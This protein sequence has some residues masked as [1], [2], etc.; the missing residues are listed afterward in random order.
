VDTAVEPLIA[1]LL[2]AFGVGLL[3]RR[4]RL[5]YTLAL[6]V[7]GLALG[8][9]DVE[10]FK[11]IRL[12][13]DLLF[14]LLLPP[15]LFEASFHLDWTRFRRDAP[16]TFLLAVPGPIIATTIT[17][18]LTMVLLRAFGWESFGWTEAFLLGAIV[19]PTDPV[20]VLSL[21]RALDV[22]RR[23]H[24]LVEGESLLND[25]IAVVL[26]L[27]V[28]ATAGLAVRSDAPS[29]LSMHDAVLYGLRTFFWMAGGGIAIGSLVGLAAS[30]VTRA[31][32]DHLVEVAL[33]AIVAW[34]SFLVAESVQASGVLACVAAGVVHG[35]VGA[36][37]SMSPTTRM[38]VID[39]WEFMAFFANTLVFLLVGLELDLGTLSTVVVPIVLALGAVLVARIAVVTLAWGAARASRRLDDIPLRWVPVL[40]WGGIRGS[41]SMVLV[42]GLP[43]GL[44]SRNF[45]VVLV[46]GVAA[47]SLL[48]QGLTMRP[49]VTRLGLSG[50]AT[51]NSIERAW[52]ERM[53]ASRALAE[54]D[55][56]VDDGR[57][58]PNDAERIREPYT[59][60]RA[61]ATRT[62]D[63]AGEGAKGRLLEQARRHLV[64]IERDVLDEAVI[65]GVASDP[66][67]RAL[68]DEIARKREA[69]S[70]DS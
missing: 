37:R 19:S 43:Y 52:T 33:T 22:D 41:V 11:A 63:S 46:F 35:N 25:G 3:A 59:R 12:T 23:L 39:F 31:I 58:A 40:V 29:I 5:P 55:R 61:D 48:L 10:A 42:L 26:F 1:L 24:L 66:V 18:T 14:V 30:A 69:I 50:T 54:I 45:L 49:L 9:L 32:D 7:A 56:W 38:A 4:F 44:E 67:A 13:P 62:L 6:V 57:L 16:L 60:T 27:I 36:R 21:F 64:A 70:S 47:A 28:A 65:D 51:P 17:A 8:F 20:S 53:M 2:V 15:L 68:G 34:G